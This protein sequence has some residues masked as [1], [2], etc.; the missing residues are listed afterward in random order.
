MR[1]LKV[2]SVAV[3]A[4]LALVEPAFAQDGAV[5][6]AGSQLGFLGAGLGIAIAAMGGALAQGKVISAT[7]ESISRNP[8]A[9]GQMFLPWILA[10]AFIESLVIFSLIIAL[11]LVGIF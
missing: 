7:V 1:L 9:A 6:V 8:G 5:V 4:V 10:L 2:L 11:K 3:A